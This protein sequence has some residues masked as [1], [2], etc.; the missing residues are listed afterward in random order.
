MIHSSPASAFAGKTTFIIYV[1][2]RRLQLEQQTVVLLDLNHFILFDAD[3]V[4]SYPVT[5]QFAALLP[6]GIWVLADSSDSLNSPPRALL[7]QEMLVVQITSP[8]PKRWKTWITKYQGS[9]YLM[10]VWEDKEIGALLC[11]LCPPIHSPSHV[12][13]QDKASRGR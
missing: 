2:L 4:W 3:G 11:V 1:L 9:L 7:T 12:L 10:D 6:A 8:A 5:H 13:C